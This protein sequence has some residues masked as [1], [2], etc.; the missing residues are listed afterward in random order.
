MSAPTRWRAVWAATAAGAAAAMQIGKAAAALPLVR[1]ETGA[2]LTLLAVYVSAISAVAAVAGIAFGGIVARMGPRRAG[3]LGLGLAA[4]GSAWGATAPGL[5]G[6]LASR[7]PEAAGFALVATSM[8]ALVGRA[9]AARDKALA[10]GVWAAWLPV[11]VAAALAVA[12]AW[13]G[14]GWRGVFWVSAAAPA[15]AALGLLA[16]VPTDGA[17]PRVPLL[18]RPPAPAAT[19]MGAFAMFSGAN[20]IVAGFLP[21][22]LLDE[23]GMAPRLGAAMGVAA[24]L[25]L[26]P[27]NLAAGWLRGRGAGGRALMAGA[28][29]GMGACAVGLLADGPAALRLGSAM[30]YG[31]FCGAIPAVIWGS[32][33]LV[34]RG[35]AE[36]PLVSGALYQGAGLGQIAGP[37]LA[38]LAVAWGDWTASLWVI[39]GAVAL[40]LALVARV[41]A[42]LYRSRPPR[43]EAAS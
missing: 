2:D 19:L 4:I 10:L 30:A 36:A 16:L 37:L 15:L 1:A 9:A 5:P 41:P 23:L 43:M 34:A 25:A 21:T 11:G 29:V 26:V 27:G 14:I 28:F 32:V 35:P 8:P 3:V 24:N 20:M 31:L 18:A 13:P 40:G 39:L 17:A 42:A 6:L 33:P 12:L 38:A 7:A 22:L